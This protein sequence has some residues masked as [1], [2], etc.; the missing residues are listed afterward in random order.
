MNIAALYHLFKQS[1]GISTDTRKIKPGN[2]FFALKGANFNGNLFALE[3]LEKGASYVVADEN[4][5]GNNSR[6][7]LVDDSLKTLQRLAQFHRRTFTGKVIAL[8]GSNGK[9]TTKELIL[10]TLATTFNT[11]ATQGNLNNHIGIPL[12]LLA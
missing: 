6:I 10:A 7:L 9:T 1:S 11:F 12:T 2:I 4:H 5:F 3:A 8:T